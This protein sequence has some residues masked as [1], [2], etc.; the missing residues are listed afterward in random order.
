MTRY[1]NWFRITS[2]LV[3]LIFSVAVRLAAQDSES[4]EAREL[5]SSGV[6]LTRAVAVVEAPAVDGNVLTDSAYNQA[7]VATGFVQS[8]PFEGQPASERT[9]VRVVYTEDT[10]Y[11]GIVCFT[12]DSS[13]IITAD[14]RRDSDL[15]ETDSFQILLDTYQDGQNGFVF[16]TNPAGVEYDGQVTNEGQGSGRFGGGG[17]GR[18]SNNRQQRGS[19][20]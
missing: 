20:G 10:L 5:T 1:N 6:P 18:P 11:F 17:G 12:E 4:N 14:S 9:E 13:T 15:T 16:G 8:R 3:L 19:G 7:Q 2:L